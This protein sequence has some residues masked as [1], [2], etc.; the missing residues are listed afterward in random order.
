M[1]SVRITDADYERLLDLR[2][3]LRRFLH[4]SEQ[5]ARAAGLPPAQHQLLLAIRG[6]RGDP[7]IG[8]LAAHLLVRH[9]SAVELVDRAQRAG[10][11][12]RV[13]DLDDHRVVRVRVTA[14]GEVVLAG[15]AA[16]HLEEIDRLLTRI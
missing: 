4:W 10:L 12:E 3:E 13:V 1:K 2:D 11:V 16:T 14:A 9:H 15:L 7:T 8:E 6:H 5:E